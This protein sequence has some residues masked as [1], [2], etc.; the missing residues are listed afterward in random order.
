MRVTLYHLPS[1]RI[2]DIAMYL[3]KTDLASFAS[4]ARRYNEICVRP[5]ARHERRERAVHV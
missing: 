3:D 5:V 1:E 2:E 4:I